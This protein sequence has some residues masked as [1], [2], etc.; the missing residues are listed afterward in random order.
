MLRFITWFQ[1][2][3]RPRIIGMVTLAYLLCAL[4]IMQPGVKKLEKLSGKPVDILDLQLGFSVEKS[5]IHTF[6]LLCG[7]SSGSSH[8]FGLGRYFVS[9]DLWVTAFLVAG[10]FFSK[11]QNPI[12]RDGSGS[13]RSG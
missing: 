12:C 13:G 10:R 4:G 7:R 1:Q 5:T 8:F 9:I 6:R 2:R 3:A 11:R